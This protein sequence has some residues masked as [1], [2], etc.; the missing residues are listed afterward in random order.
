MGR[1]YGG[2]EEGKGREGLKREREL[3]RSRMKRKS[4]GEIEEAGN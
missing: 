1:V 2:I 4:F 3:G